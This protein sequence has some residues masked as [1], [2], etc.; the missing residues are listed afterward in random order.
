ME[1]EYK[2]QLAPFA[3]CLKCTNY[4]LR[5]ATYEEKVKIHEKVVN[6]WFLTQKDPD[7]FH[8]IY[9]DNCG[10]FETLFNFSG[11]DDLYADMKEAMSA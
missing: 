7:K 5:M 8:L 6:E 11:W 4:S 3:N 9:C 10:F 2:I 1:E